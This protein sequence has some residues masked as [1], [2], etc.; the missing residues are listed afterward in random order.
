MSKK[1]RQRIVLRIA[2]AFVFLAAAVSLLV[3]AMTSES[4]R[5]GGEQAPPPTSWYETQTPISGG[6][7]SGTGEPTAAPTAESSGTPPP[8]PADPGGGSDSGTS[9]AST[10]IASIGSLLSGVAAVG[11][12]LHAVHLSR[13]NRRPTTD[14]DAASASTPG[15]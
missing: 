7:P 1:S 8:A 14:E 12:L 3:V 15:P 5:D 11:T 9:S 4:D 10:L 6:E 13:Q 2:L